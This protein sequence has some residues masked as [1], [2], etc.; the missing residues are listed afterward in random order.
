M[1]SATVIYLVFLVQF[2]I[3]EIQNQRVSFQNETT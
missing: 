3:S 2:E 1:L